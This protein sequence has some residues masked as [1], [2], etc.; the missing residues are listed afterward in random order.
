MKAAVLHGPR[1]L[2]I[3]EV[4]T[5][6]AGPHDLLVRI[7]SCAICGTDTQI[8]FG[9]HQAGRYPMI[10]GH[11][12]SADIVEVGRELSGYRVGERITFWVHFG[13]FAEYNCF[14]PAR[15]AV[16][17]LPAHV[18]WDAGA[19]TQL[20]CAC[21]RGVDCSGLR[22][23]HTAL[24]LGQGP[25]GLL[26]LQGARV[27]GAGT[28]LGVDLLDSRLAMS[29]RVGA[30]ATVNASEPGWPERVLEAAGEVDVA[31]DCMND[32]L[33]PNED[34][35]EQ[36]L[37]AMRPGG[38][39]VVLSLGSRRRGPSPHRLVGRNVTIKPSYVPFERARELIGVA[40]DLV[41]RG[42]VDVDS[43][44]THR[45]SLDEVARGMELTREQPESV[46]KI[47][48]QVAP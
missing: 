21:L 20:L 12:A 10:L 9:A 33:S 43:F 40:C 42:E 44:I 17:E 8:Y 48:V 6:Q 16:G 1:D 3:E 37:R 45:I 29:E 30:T 18:T 39:I 14:D 32:D 4:P 36:L 25:V 34:A 19:N 35:L 13:S 5:P 31:F 7:H 46:I 23:G 15:V 27:Y 47:M 26:T 22:E 38:Q 24:V 2:R 11:E 41:G 28:T